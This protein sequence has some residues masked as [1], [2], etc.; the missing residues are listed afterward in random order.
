M[1]ISEI[2]QILQTSDATGTKSNIIRPLLW[3]IGTLISSTIAAF[4]FSAP[5]WF[6]IM[7]GSLACFVII[8][9]LTVYGYCLIKHP[10][11]LRSEKFVIHKMALE[12]GFM[13]MI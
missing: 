2:K 5:V 7:L 4:S 8:F 12:K 3:L 13:E 9:T 10:D 11:Y 6:A 1:G